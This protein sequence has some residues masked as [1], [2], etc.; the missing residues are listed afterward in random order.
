MVTTSD[1]TD[2][3]RS[4]RSTGS[5]PVGQEPRTRTP[6]A[7]AWISVALIPVFFVLSFVVQ[8]VIY[9]L[10]GYD[11]STG[12]APLWADLA[13]ALPG[14]AILLLPCLAGVAHGWRAARAG[15]RAGLVPAVLAALLGVGAVIL[16]VANI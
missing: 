5:R 4:T 11:P 3:T 13:A 10:T 7:R 8:T 16:T 9:A 14:L 1:S 6:L 2:P 15:V 12:T